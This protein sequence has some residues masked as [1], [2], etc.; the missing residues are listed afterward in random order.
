MHAIS[1]YRGNEPHTQTNKHT[2]PKQIGPITIYTAPQCNDHNESVCYNN[3]IVERKKRTGIGYVCCGYDGVKHYNKRKQE[4]VEQL[5]NVGR[6]VIGK[7][8]RAPEGPATQSKVPAPTVVHGATDAV[9]PSVR[10]AVGKQRD[11]TRP[12]QPTRP[13]VTGCPPQPDVAICVPPLGTC[14]P[15]LAV[16]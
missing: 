12:R 16:L 15:H 5:L 13:L 10:Q 1:S 7:H 3:G 2:H 9:P 6:E 14:S 4:K 11:R 8:D